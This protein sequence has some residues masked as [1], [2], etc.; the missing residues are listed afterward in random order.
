MAGPIYL[1][2][3]LTGCHRARQIRN[4]SSANPLL[5][6]GVSR[7]RLACTS[8][9]FRSA[10]RL[11]LNFSALRQLNIPNP[12]LKTKLTHTPLNAKSPTACRP[13]HT[14][15]TAVPTLPTEHMPPPAFGPIPYSLWADGRPMKVNEVSCNLRDLPLISAYSANPT[16]LLVRG[17]ILSCVPSIPQ[18][19][20][21]SF[22]LPSS[23]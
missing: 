4:R 19:R 11:P 21:R 20:T 17:A 14:S 15:T 8:P 5:L 23:A 13:D 7:S 6:F 22:P 9:P 12:A 18:S 2:S 1:L 16:T 3:R 10:L